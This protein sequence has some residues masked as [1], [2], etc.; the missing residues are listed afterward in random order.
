VLGFDG[1][2]GRLEPGYKADIVFLDLG[3]LTYV[4]LNDP[5]TQ[6]VMAETGAAVDSVMVG[7]EFVY[8]DRHFPGIDLAQLRGRIETRVAELGPH[9]TATRESLTALER[10]VTSFCIGLAPDR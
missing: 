3:D 1:V 2:L 9:L 8:R 10:Y 5:V 7:G 4:P 6:L